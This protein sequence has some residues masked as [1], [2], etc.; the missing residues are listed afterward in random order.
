MYWET[1]SFTEV[2]EPVSTVVP[3]S[4]RVCRDLLKNQCSAEP[5]AARCA[6]G[7]FY[8]DHIGSVVLAWSPSGMAQSHTLVNLERALEVQTTFT[9][10]TEEI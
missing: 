4:A 9:E 2:K 3:P 7:V 5:M 10:T 6:P 1:E 8:R